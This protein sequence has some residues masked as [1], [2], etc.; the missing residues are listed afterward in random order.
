MA[1]TCA[2]RMNVRHREQR[3]DEIKCSR[4]CRVYDE[5]E[6]LFVLSVTAE[7]DVQYDDMSD[8]CVCVCGE[9]LLPKQD[10]T[11]QCH[12][13]YLCVMELER[14]IVSGSRYCFNAFAIAI[15][16]TKKKRRK[17]KYKKK[18]FHLFWVNLGLDAFVS[19]SMRCT[20][21]FC[22]IHAVRNA[23][24][25]SII[26]LVWMFKTS[27]NLWNV[28]SILL[29]AHRH[30]S[31]QL[32]Y[33]FIFLVFDR[34]NYR[35]SWIS[36]PSNSEHYRKHTKQTRWKSRQGMIE[37]QWRIDRQ[38]FT[39]QT[40]HTINNHIKFDNLRALRPDRHILSLCDTTTT[41]HI[42]CHIENIWRESILQ[43]IHFNYL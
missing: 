7:N 39:S 42:Y 16:A 19:T 14:G 36:A 22:L 38:P 2:Y 34:M 20:Q 23:K 24:V 3:W 9:N 26:L 4:A 43:R 10:E 35:K 1:S 18:F 32:T 15:C 5:I 13:N 40:L 37:I 25:C 27:K 29:C 41:N 8:V 12:V 6:A 17:K 33:F 28:P 30:G 11:R 31:R 21:R